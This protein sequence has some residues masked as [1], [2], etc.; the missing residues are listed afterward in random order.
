MIT[1]SRY[2]AGSHYSIASYVYTSYINSVVLP[3]LPQQEWKITTSYKIGLGRHITRTCFQCAQLNDPCWRSHINMLQELHLNCCTCS[4]YLY[5]TAINSTVVRQQNITTKFEAWPSVTATCRKPPAR[6]MYVGS[7]GTYFSL[8]CIV[9]CLCTTCDSPIVLNCR[10]DR[11][12]WCTSRTMCCLKAWPGFGDIRSTV[13]SGTSDIVHTIRLQY[14]T[15]VHCTA[16]RVEPYK[17]VQVSF[18]W[19]VLMMDRA[20]WLA[21]S[22][23]DGKVVFKI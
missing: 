4:T 6:W 20:S 22:T 9:V 18:S 3:S 5:C 16:V 7:R 12:S 14:Y 1:C 23:S 19:K 15:A 10:M 2:A 21:T 13:F 8:T 17:L 11:A